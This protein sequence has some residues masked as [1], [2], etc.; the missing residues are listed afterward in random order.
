[1]AA[2]SAGLAGALARQW[3]AGRRPARVRVEPSARI[4]V[5]VSSLHPVARSAV[6]RLR[7]ATAGG[8]DRPAVHVVTTPTACAPA[9]GTAAAVAS[10]FGDRVVAQLARSPYDVLVLVGGDGAAATLDRL[11]ATAVTVHSALAPG[12]PIGAIVGGPAHGVRLVTT[13]GGFGDAESLVR[14]VDRLQ[15]GS[16]HRKE[17]T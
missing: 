1:V 5:G 4:L 12:V 10:D 14:I 13:S 3:S 8:A 11:G 9:G 16:H 7:D 2:G 6:R 17:P 15:A